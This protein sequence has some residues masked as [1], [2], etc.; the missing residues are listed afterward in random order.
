LFYESSA[1]STIDPHDLRKGLRRLEKSG[2]LALVRY[3]GDVRY[4]I[5]EDAA[6]DAMR[7]AT[8]TEQYLT[9]V[10][11][12][13]F[14]SDRVTSNRYRE[15]FLAV[16]AHLFAELGEESIELISGKRRPLPPPGRIEAQVASIVSSEGNSGIDAK[17]LERVLTEF[18]RKEDLHFDF[19]KWHL[20][21]SLFIAKV[22]GLDESGQLL[23]K[24]L[25]SGARLYIDTNVLIPGLDE[26]DPDH[27]L[28]LALCSVCKQLDIELV[29]SS[30]T[31]EELERWVK[32]QADTLSKVVDLIPAELESKLSSPFLERYRV[33]QAEGIEITTDALC[34]KY[35]DAPEKLVRKWGFEIDRAAG[36]TTDTFSPDVE[37]FARF[38]QTRYR[39]RSRRP[40]PGSG[41]SRR[42]TLNAASHD[43]ALIKRIEQLRDDGGNNVWLITTDRSLPGAVPLGSNHTSFAIVLDSFLQ[44]ASPF[45][46]YGQ[47]D[48]EFGAAFA[49]MMRKRLLPQSRILRLE[50][51]LLLREMHISTK[52]LPVADVEECITMIKSQ[53]MRLDPS[54]PSDRE[55]LFREVQRFFADPGRQYKRE[56]ERLELDVER[57]ACRETHL[58]SQVGAQDSEIAAL[59]ASLQLQSHRRSV[60]RRLLLI[61][62]LAIVMFGSVI[63]GALHWGEGTNWY[64]Q[65]LESWVVLIGAL[66]LA[67]ITGRLILSPDDLRKTEW[68]TIGW[69]LR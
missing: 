61:S 24:E 1:G 55:V 57:A 34:A 29:V 30:A 2:R 6:Q 20:A 33:L 18:F 13:L 9:R 36:D 23:S 51:F 35:I 5:G 44:W 41:I 48:A 25:F 38:L 14:H 3:S 69:L 63:M 16:L 7:A 15:S 8:D 60:S 19:V 62:A 37:N 49:E 39:H 56:L 28:F 4:C 17:V 47:D 45:T 22:L 27:C 52:E 67:G 26:S 65:L 21:Q 66:G 43:S 40:F 59:Q 53:V 32:A 12:E 46:Q 42:K 54:L 64:Q 50:D 10:L 58:K 31:L 11:D 68:P